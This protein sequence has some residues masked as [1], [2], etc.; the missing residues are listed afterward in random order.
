MKLC[1]VEIGL[2]IFA[3][4]HRFHMRIKYILP[5][6]VAILILKNVEAQFL[7]PKF[8]TPVKQEQFSSENEETSPLPFN[9]GKGIYYNRIYISGEADDIEITGHDFWIS[10]ID[11]KGWQKP[12]RVLRDGE[13]SGSNIIIGTSDDGNRLYLLNIKQEKKEYKEKIIYIDRIA[14]NKWTEPKEIVIPGFAIIPG[15]IHFYVTPNGDAILVS[16]PPNEGVTEEDIFVSVKDKVS[17]QWSSLINLG[18]TINTERYDLGSFLSED[19]KTLYFSSEGHGGYGASDIFVTYRLSDSWTEWTE[20]VNIGE[21]IN[22]KDYESYFVIAN[23]KEVYFVSDYKDIHN[24]IYKA[25]GTGDVK[26][27]RDSLGGIFVYRGLPVE[28]FTLIVED[29]FGNIIDEL[30]TDEYGKFKFA[31]RYKLSANYTVR[32]KDKGQIKYVGSKIYLID[33]EGNNL[34]RFVYNEEGSFTNSKQAEEGVLYEGKF[35]YKNLPTTK[36]GIVILDENKFPID[37][38]YTDNNGNFQYRRL[39]FDYGGI[40]LIPLDIDEEDY[41]NVELT[42]VNKQENNQH[43]II[44]GKYKDLI[45]KDVLAKKPLLK[46]PF[47]DDLEGDEMFVEK[48]VI[49]FSFNAY[50]VAEGQKVKINMIIEMLKQDPLLKVELV[51]HTDDKGGT[52]I[53]KKVG[54]LRANSA[55]SFMLKAGIDP[56]RISVSSE[57][58]MSPIMSNDTETGRIKNRRVEVHVMK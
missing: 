56:S 2:F 51:G 9:K 28:N 42:L 4:I 49:E 32:P 30:V 37:T 35:N 25:E 20:P 53:N 46:E 3:A 19:L 1:R 57:G 5:L 39:A 18:K 22:T 8:H 55:K 12:Y 36:S 6:L 21:P 29:E 11:E 26:F 45:Q 7:L 34:E 38:V 44:P 15:F 33:N 24:N 48:R 52:L 47:S 58:E 14:K 41:L 13:V 23:N 40:T 17:G 43:E 31:K 27:E 16:M 54:K 10:T 50:E